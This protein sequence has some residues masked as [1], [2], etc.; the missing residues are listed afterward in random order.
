MKLVQA[1]V[2]RMFPN[3]AIAFRVDETL[4]YAKADKKKEIVVARIVPN[5]NESLT[6]SVPM[7]SKQKLTTF[8]NVNLL[9]GGRAAIRKSLESAHERNGTYVPAPT[10]KMIDTA[11]ARIEIQQYEIAVML[12]ASHFGKGVDISNWDFLSAAAKNEFHYVGKKKP[13]PTAK[14]AKEIT[15]DLVKRADKKPRQ[16]RQQKITE[17]QALL[18]AVGATFDGNGRMSTNTKPAATKKGPRAAVADVKKA[19]A[20]PERKAHSVSPAKAPVSAKAN[21]AVPSAGK[22]TEADD[23]IYTELLEDMRKLTGRLAQLDIAR[24]RGISI[25]EFDA[26]AK[27]RR[28]AK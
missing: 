4:F 20:K 28:V 27:S 9:K 3:H 24:K 15:G 26:K 16:P 21:G 14:L 12:L 18:K 11:K 2:R 5:A 23:T 10:D 13:D 25:I 17:G 19:A 6:I 7:G 8:A 22:W 1:N